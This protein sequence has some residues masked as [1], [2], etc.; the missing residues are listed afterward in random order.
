LKGAEL[1]PA[2]TLRA[3]IANQAK[4]HNAIVFAVSDPMLIYIKAITNRVNPQ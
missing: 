1:A 2:A 3:K 4:K